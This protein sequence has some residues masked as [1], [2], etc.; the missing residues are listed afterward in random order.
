[1]ARQV[2]EQVPESQDQVPPIDQHVDDGLH[3]ATLQ[4][5]GE[6]S[7]D[8]LGSTILDRDHGHV[9]GDPE[10]GRLALDQVAHEPDHRDEQIRT[11]SISNS[12]TSAPERTEQYVDL[13]AGHHCIAGVGVVQ[14]RG[15]VG[16]VP[17]L[18]SGPCRAQPWLR[19]T[20]PGCQ[21]ALLGQTELTVTGRF[22]LVV[23]PLPSWP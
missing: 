5:P 22:E 14:R 7:A 17:S 6:Q 2:V 8:A 4:R 18:A 23:A 12:S 11:S 15:C 21:E 3:Q 10:A 13:P 19:P 20:R 9:A 1:M 16:H